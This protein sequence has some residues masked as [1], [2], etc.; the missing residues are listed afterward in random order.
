MNLEKDENAPISTQ[1]SKQESFH[2]T[3]NVE[4]KLE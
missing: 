3:L 1:Y 4:N 2:H